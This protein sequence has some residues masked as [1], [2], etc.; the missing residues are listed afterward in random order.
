MCF[1]PV[2]LLGAYT[3]ALL[4]MLCGHGPWPCSPSLGMYRLSSH[5]LT[6]HPITHSLSAAVYHA[7]CRIPC[8]VLAWSLAHRW[9]RILEDRVWAGGERSQAPSRDTYGRLGYRYSTTWYVLHRGYQAMQA[10][11]KAGRWQGESKMLHV[12]R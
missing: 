12:W 2:L 3:Y 4:S 9:D 10:S 8:P 6:S 5:V 7:L 11:G 1:S